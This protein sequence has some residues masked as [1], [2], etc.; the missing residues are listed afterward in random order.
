MACKSCTQTMDR[1]PSRHEKV[2]LR[3]Q[4]L[5]H[6]GQRDR[7]A[8]AP[9]LTYINATKVFTPKFK[10]LQAAKQ[11]RAE[12]AP[13][14]ANR[15]SRNGALS[16][17]APAGRHPKAYGPWASAFSEK[18]I[19]EYMADTA[20]MRLCGALYEGTRTEIVRG[21]KTTENNALPRSQCKCVNAPC[22]LKHSRC[23]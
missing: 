23:I 4:S 3:Q 5:L 15:L 6:G 1:Q 14:C 11:P 19:Q 20:R 18:T 17:C 9:H 22:F 21:T 12:T 13:F 2:E 7:V 8:I 16:A 10:P